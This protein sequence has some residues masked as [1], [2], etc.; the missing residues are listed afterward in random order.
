MLLFL[1]YKDKYLEELTQSKRELFYFIKYS[2][3]KLSPQISYND[4]FPESSVSKDGNVTKP[5]T[6]MVE[7]FI[8][9]ETNYLN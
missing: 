4:F 8:I 5:T 9:E 3:L 1:N 6:M 2:G 7:D